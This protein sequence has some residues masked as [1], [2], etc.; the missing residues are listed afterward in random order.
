M[1]TFT[2]PPPLPLEFD[3][4]EG[5]DWFAVEAVLDMRTVSQGRG[6]AVKQYLVIKCMRGKAAMV[7]TKAMHG[8]PDAC[9]KLA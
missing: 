4:G 2:Q 5:G 7:M 8:A 1:A 6:R 3:D 9:T